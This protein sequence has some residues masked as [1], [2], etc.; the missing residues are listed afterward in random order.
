[1]KVRVRGEEMHCSTLSLNS[2][3]DVVCGQRNTLVTLTLEK[4]PSFYCT[5]GYKSKYRGYLYLV[6]D[7]GSLIEYEFSEFELTA[8]ILFTNSRVLRCFFSLVFI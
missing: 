8:T 3:L 4:D 5:G 6:L 1:M 7:P 2:S